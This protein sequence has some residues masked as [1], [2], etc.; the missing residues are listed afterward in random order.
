MENQRG[1]G[2]YFA[3]LVTTAGEELSGLKMP[4]EFGVCRS[5][6]DIGSEDFDVQKIQAH[7]C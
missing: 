3:S 6:Q 1:V 2:M 4:Q 7:T 5:P